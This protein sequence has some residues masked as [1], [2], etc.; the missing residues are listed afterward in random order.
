MPLGRVKV[1]MDYRDIDTGERQLFWEKDLNSG[2]N[3]LSDTTSGT[4][5][6]FFDQYN[7]YHSI[8]RI[9]CFLKFQVLNNAQGNHVQITGSV[10]LPD[11]N[12]V[13]V[14]DGQSGIQRE[15]M[16]HSRQIEIIPTSQEL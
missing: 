2:I 10:P 12:A 6:Y 3:L 1:T 16:Y 7:C 11:L 4:L 14:A 8:S 5:K 9:D 13:L 15:N